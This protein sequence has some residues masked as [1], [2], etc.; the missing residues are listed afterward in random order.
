MGIS[1]SKK[2]NGQN[3]ER[4]KSVMSSNSQ[5]KFLFDESDDTAVIET[6]ENM[7]ERLQ[8][9]IGNS[10]NVQRNMTTGNVQRKFTIAVSRIA[11]KH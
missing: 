8:F 4:N 1:C 7:E 6:E 5:W 10:G 3:V 9:L 11:V 2:P